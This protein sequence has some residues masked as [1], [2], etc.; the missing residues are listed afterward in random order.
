MRREDGQTMAEYGVTLT[1]ITLAIITAIAALS[2]SIFD[3]V[4]RATDLL[5]G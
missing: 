2:G 4:N 1:V 5:P 3:A